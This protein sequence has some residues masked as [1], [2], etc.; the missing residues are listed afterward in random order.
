M[1]RIYARRKGFLV[2]I[3]DIARTQI[4]ETIDWL[5]AHGFMPDPPAGDPWQRTPDGLP[6][7]PRHG[8]AM[9]KRERQGDCWHSHKIID[10]RTGEILYCRGYATGNEA[11]GYNL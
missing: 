8:V 2:E 3:D 10:P 11:D 4:D 1:P 6:L 7:C 9:A 5:I